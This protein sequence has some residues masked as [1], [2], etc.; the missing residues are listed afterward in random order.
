MLAQHIKINSIQI[1]WN[2][3]LSLGLQDPDTAFNN[4]FN[5]LNALVDQHAPIKTLSKK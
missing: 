1:D 4:F 5:S 2:N 3:L